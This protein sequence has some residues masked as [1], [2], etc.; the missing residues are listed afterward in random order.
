MVSLSA[1]KFTILGGNDGK[2]VSLKEQG[3]SRSLVQNKTDNKIAFFSDGNQ[4]A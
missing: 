1:N 2:K 4:L 3:K